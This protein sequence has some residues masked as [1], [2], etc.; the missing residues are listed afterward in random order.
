M[1]GREVRIDGLV[2]RT[3]RDAT[4]S[5]SANVAFDEVSAVTLR[6]SAEE[7]ATL[8]TALGSKVKLV[9]SL[10][11]GPPDLRELASADAEGGPP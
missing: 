7:H 1:I 6:I 4:V 5:Y 3:H 11:I 9:M 8:E 10:R 2:R